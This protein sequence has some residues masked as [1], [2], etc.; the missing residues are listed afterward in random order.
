MLGEFVGSGGPIDL[1]DLLGRLFEVPGA[2][3]KTLVHRWVFPL[4]DHPILPNI[5]STFWTELPKGIA[6][7]VRRQDFTHRQFGEIV[8]RALLRVGGREVEVVDRD[9][10]TDQLGAHT[11][12][13]IELR[14]EILE[15]VSNQ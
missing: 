14:V 8:H 10:A 3:N 11:H 7:R 9:S 2:R 15:T 4:K 13:K 12:P 1:N 5:G 6:L